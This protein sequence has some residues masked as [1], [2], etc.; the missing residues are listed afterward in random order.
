MKRKTLISLIVLIALSLLLAAVLFFRCKTARS[1]PGRDN[2][3]ASETAISDAEIPFVSKRQLEN[4]VIIY[5]DLNE[6]EL[7][8]HNSS[9]TPEEIRVDIYMG[10]GFNDVAKAIVQPGETVTCAK[11]FNGEPYNAFIPGIFSGRILVY[12]S[13]S[14]HLKNRIDGLE[15]RLYHSYQD[16]YDVLAV[17]EKQEREVMLDEEEH[18]PAAYRFEVDLKTEEVW[19]GLYGLFA[20]W[21]KLDSYV[22]AVIDG[23]EILIAK[24][25]HL[26]PRSIAY[27]LYL[28]PGLSDRLTEGEISTGGHV[29]S[30]YSDT[31]EFYD[32]IP[33]EGF[34]VKRSA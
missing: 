5:Q 17:P 12:D 1:L 10:D 29:D 18:R 16:N 11:T 32:S 14:G 15:I 22:Y 30:F 13:E 28:E 3:T 34:D 2:I 31:G 24:C 21:K 33:V 7:Y 6:V 27:I 26:P 19:G 20:E 9:N 8:Y 23:E 25:E 4:Q